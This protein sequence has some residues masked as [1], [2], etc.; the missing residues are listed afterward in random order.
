MLQ[1][2]KSKSNARIDNLDAKLLNISTSFYFRIENNEAQ[3][4]KLKKKKG[5]SLR[6]QHW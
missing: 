3:L 2:I 4:Q 5:D 1:N 6:K